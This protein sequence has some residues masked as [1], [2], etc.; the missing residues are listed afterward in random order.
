MCSNNC[1]L[2]FCIKKI[3]LNT[4]GKRDTLLNNKQNFVCYTATII[5]HIVAKLN[6]FKGWL[7]NKQNCMCKGYI[8]H[9]CYYYFFKRRRLFRTVIM[10]LVLKVFLNGIN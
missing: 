2:S 1:V 6:I 4:C 7:S 10:S 5:K 8:S 3:Q 9:A